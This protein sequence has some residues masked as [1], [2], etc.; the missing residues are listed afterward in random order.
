MGVHRTTQITSGVALGKRLTIRV[1]CLKT[2]VEIPAESAT[3]EKRIGKTS[4]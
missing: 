3:E 4:N 1:V 2:E